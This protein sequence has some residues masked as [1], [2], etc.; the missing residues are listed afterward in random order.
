MDA[1]ADFGRLVTTFHHEEPDR[2]PLVEAAIDYGIMNQFLGKPVTSDDLAAQGEFW[3]QAG[4]DY[5]PLTVGMMQPG[6]VTG[7]S[8]IS[9]V[10]KKALLH[11]YAEE[12]G[13]EAWNLERRSWIQSEADLGL[14]VAGRRSAG[15]QQFPPG[16]GLLA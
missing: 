5:I 7:E 10:I 9:K 6:R 15:L 4:Y 2:V 8:A 16:P 12:D 13:T 14:A 11:D 3:C 1:Q